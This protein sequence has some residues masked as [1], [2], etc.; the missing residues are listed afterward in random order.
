M[1]AVYAILTGGKTATGKMLITTLKQSVIGCVICYGLM[2]N[3]SLGMINFSAGDILYISDRGEVRNMSTMGSMLIMM[4]GFM[5]MFFAMF[6]SKYI[7]MSI[8]VIFGT[9]SMK[10]LTNGFVALGLSATMRDIVQGFFLLVLLVISANS[11][12]FERRRADK[13]FRQ[14]CF[15]EHS[16]EEAAS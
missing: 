10:M 11:G 12:F 7:N 2:I 9:F 8:A 5:G 13:L 6:L 14:Q 1:W 3:M 15:S 16:P 4:D